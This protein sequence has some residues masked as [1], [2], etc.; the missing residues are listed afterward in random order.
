MFGGHNY[1]RTCSCTRSFAL[2]GRGYH[3]GFCY[4]KMPPNPSLVNRKL[5]GKIN[6]ILL[7]GLALAESCAIYG[8]VV[9]LM[10]FTK[11]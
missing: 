11:L 2:Y 5:P 8:F 7:L 3:D 1:D 6:A 9:A 10:L 4:R